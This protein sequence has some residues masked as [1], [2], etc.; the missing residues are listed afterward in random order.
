[1]YRQSNW[2]LH[3]VELQRGPTT[4]RIEKDNL[5]LL[6]QLNCMHVMHA[7]ADDRSYGHQ[8]DLSLSIN[9][10]V[11]GYLTRVH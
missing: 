3:P 8:L 10:Y 7:P 11:A 2:S 1:M 4:D 6:C 5:L 9:P